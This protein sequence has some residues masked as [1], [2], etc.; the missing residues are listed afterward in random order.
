M[1]QPHRR[2]I[3][4]A[5]L[6]LPFASLVAGAHEEKS[7]SSFRFGI[8]ESLLS[9]QMTHAVALI[10]AKPMAEVFALTGMARPDFL[11]DK[12]VNLAKKLHAQE[13]QLGMMPGIEFGWLQ[14]QRQGLVPL[15]AVFA[16]DIRLK[17]LVLARQDA[18]HKNVLS[19]QGKTIAL[20]R[21]TL[22]HTL[23]F[24]D[25]II[26]QLGGQPKGFFGKCMQ[27]SDA[28]SAIESVIEGETESVL[29][30]GDGWATFQER[31]P[32]RAKKLSIVAES[33]PFPTSIVLHKPGTLSE[34]M[35][36]KLKTI[37]LTAHTK[38]FSRQILNFWRISKFVPYCADYEAVLGSILRDIPKPIIPVAI[39]HS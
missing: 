29:V 27:S 1:M 35:V 10:Q 30:D 34:D 14:A 9:G 24:M 15:A 6:A 12:P 8:S 26:T 22:H 28:D 3:L 2:D 21:R 38:A 31:K 33:S 11:F 7:A 18:Q 36:E 17:A 16:S 25:H 39:S 5:A 13:I 20:P 37:L 32:G 4:R 23:V 19:L